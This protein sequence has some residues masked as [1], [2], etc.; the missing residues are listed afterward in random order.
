[1]ENVSPRS[2]QVLNDRKKQSKFLH[3]YVLSIFLYRR[4]LWEIRGSRNVVPKKDTENSIDVERRNEIEL[5]KKM[6]TK[7]SWTVHEERGLGKLT[8][9]RAYYGQ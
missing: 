9:H 5:L 2:E 7:I 8:P 3:C 6:A 1:M 4:E